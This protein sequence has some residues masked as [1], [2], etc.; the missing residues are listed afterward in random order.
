MSMR[1]LSGIISLITDFGIQ[2]GYVGAM[3]GVILSINPRASIVDISHGVERHDLIQAALMLRSTCRYFPKG[4]IHVVVVD[5]G[6]GGRRKPLLVETE[7]F[8]FVGPDNGVLSL[9]LEAE[10]PLQVVSIED[11]KYILPWV[12]DTF[13][14]RDIF[15]PAAAHCSLG[16]PA[17]RFGPEVKTYRSMQLSRPRVLADGLQGEVII[18][19]HFGNLVTNISCR[20]LDEHLGTAP[21]TIRLG[22]TTI[23]KISRSY[24]EVP[25]GEPL[26]I[27][28]GWDLLEIAVNGGDARSVLGVERGEAVA[29]RRG[30]RD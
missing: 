30:S 13:H 20:H 22:K 26:A 6:V 2:D 16:V 19:D 25:Q 12:S 11:S 10:R 24:Q 9:A 21:L 18:V 1:A 8:F 5:P 15:A 4:S 3:K 23:S 7:K 27:I 17:D 28:G 29:V 14:G